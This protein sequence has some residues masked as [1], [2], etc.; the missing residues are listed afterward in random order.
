MELPE[1]E[2][3]GFGVIADKDEHSPI[4]THSD[5]FLIADL[6]RRKEVIW[7]EPRPNPY[8]KICREKYPKPSVTGDNP[9]D[10]ELEIHR[11][12]AEILK[13]CIYVRGRDFG[14]YSADALKAAGS[15]AMMV[16]SDEPQEW[17]NSLIKY[18]A[19]A[20]YFD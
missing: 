10:E 6:I 16:S 1:I 19:Y 3:I 12:I 11:Q 18:R 9:S 7:H 2:R 20:G 14:S 4:F 17:L 13:D 15:D 8:A 5:R